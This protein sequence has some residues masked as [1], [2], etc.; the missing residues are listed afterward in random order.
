MHIDFDTIA[1][2]IANFV[3]NSPA[4]LRP[5]HSRSNIPSSKKVLFYSKR[6]GI[7]RAKKLEQLDFTSALQ[8]VD[9]DE[10]VTESF[11]APS[12]YTSSPVGSLKKEDLMPV[13][14]TKTPSK[15]PSFIEASISTSKAN[16]LS[17]LQSGIFWIDVTN[18]SKSEIQNYSNLFGI[19]PLTGEDILSEETREKAEDF[20]NYLFI[21]I[22]TF[23]SD[24]YSAN[25]LNPINLSIVVFND[26]VLS[27]HTKPIPH[28]A[29]VLKRIDQLKAYDQVHLTSEWISYALGMSRIQHQ[30][31][32]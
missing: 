6:T 29:N 32:M 31:T 9:F 21:S 23:D 11:S 7:I 25:Y 2:H 13:S 4:G 17:I 10:A 24:P 28:I 8:K 19:H 22:K 1:G 27:F 3:S 16:V 12:S 15:A 5:R 26:C 20:P 18:A 30:S 14:M